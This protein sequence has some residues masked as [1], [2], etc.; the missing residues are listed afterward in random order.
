MSIRRVLLELCKMRTISSYA[1][2]CRVGRDVVCLKHCWRSRFGS[3]LCYWV[4]LLLRS[5][6]ADIRPIGANKALSCPPASHHNSFNQ[7]SVRLYPLRLTKLSLLR[8]LT[9]S[10]QICLERRK[11]CRIYWMDTACRCAPKNRRYYLLY[12]SVCFFDAFLTAKMPCNKTSK[13]L[14]V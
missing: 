12:V 6:S 10:Y 14:E 11:Y 5:R 9:N 1:A 4:F 8:R 2:R 7:F 3:H 13:I